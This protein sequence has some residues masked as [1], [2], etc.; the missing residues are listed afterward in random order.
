MLLGIKLVMR[1]MLFKAVPLAMAKRRCGGARRHSQ[2]LA[3][4]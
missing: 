2:N 3:F 1:V 4:L